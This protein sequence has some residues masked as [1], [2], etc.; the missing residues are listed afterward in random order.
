MPPRTGRGFILDDIFTKRPRRRRWTNQNPARQPE[1]PDL[2]SPTETMLVRQCMN[3]SPVIKAPWA[4]QMYRCFF[5]ACVIYFS[6][7]LRLLHHGSPI[8]GILITVGFPLCSLLGLLATCIRVPASRWVL[9]IFGILIPG[10]VSVGIF[11][12]TRHDDW[13]EWLFIPFFF[14][15]WLALPVYGAIIL[16][17]DKK[18][19]DYFARSAA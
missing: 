13:V 19:N 14:F 1:Y 18:T 3:I 6:S 12:V 15:I 9:S 17:R 11:S 5:L 16:F 4:I 2:P 7:Y 10:L 8:S